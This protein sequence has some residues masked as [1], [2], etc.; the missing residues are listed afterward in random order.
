MGQPI[1]EEDLVDFGIRRSDVKNIHFKIYFLSLLTSLF[2]S[3]TYYIY[4]DK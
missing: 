3:I 1:S 2:F 4:L